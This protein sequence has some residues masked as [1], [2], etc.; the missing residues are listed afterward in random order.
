MAQTNWVIAQLQKSTRDIEY[1]IQSITTRGDTDDR[2][3][4]TIDQ[5]GIFEREIDRAVSQGEIDFAVHSLKDIPSTLD[6]SLCI[7]AVPRRESPNDI[8]ITV[9]GSDLDSIHK[10]DTIGTSSLRRA[11]QIS[12]QRPDLK[13][14][15]LRGNVDTRVE[16]MNSGTYGGIVLAEAGIMRLNLDVKYHVLN[17][18]E[19]VPSPG[20]GALGIVARTDDH[21]T[22]NMLQSIESY[23][24]R[25][26]VSAER[27]LSSIVDS[28]CRFPIGAYATTSDGTISLHVVA[29]SVDGSKS[30]SVKRTG[31]INSPDE[32]GISAGEELVD[33]GIRDLA[34][35][36]RSGLE[37]WNRS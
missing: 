27:A 28:G 21:K 32:L 8:L 11:V 24:S 17:V 3:L 14:H 12:R 31:K 23:E 22:I 10:G 35:N 25:A 1:T 6:D 34:V 33:M 26:A 16:K 13:I 20:Q 9:N 29:F 36:W 7:A 2:P 15:P 30:L 19:F 18:D 4:F 5:K 37:V